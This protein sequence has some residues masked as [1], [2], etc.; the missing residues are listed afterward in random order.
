MQCSTV[1]CLYTTHKKCLMNEWINHWINEQLGTYPSLAG[2]NWIKQ[3]CM[4]KGSATS[5][6]E[7]TCV[8]HLSVGLSCAR[9]PHRA[10]THQPANGI[11]KERE[12]GSW[13]FSESSAQS[14]FNVSPDSIGCGEKR[15]GDEWPKYK[16]TQIPDF[17]LI[18]ARMRQPE[19]VGS[20]HTES[21]WTKNLKNVPW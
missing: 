19:R 1:Q 15:K 12:S 16:E 7:R 6:R 9:L 17:V 14:P 11:I 10:V 18:S 8:L 13:A 3:T 21:W 20:G 2:L 4:C 5:L